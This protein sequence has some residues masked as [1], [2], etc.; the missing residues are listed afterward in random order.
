MAKREFDFKGL[1]SP[2][3][4]MNMTVKISSMLPGDFLIVTADCDT[5][6]E[7]VIMWCKK[8]SKKLQWIKDVGNN[9]KQCQILA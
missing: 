6:E 3:L 7:D 5:F 8:N 2:Q 1:K 9:S 4:L